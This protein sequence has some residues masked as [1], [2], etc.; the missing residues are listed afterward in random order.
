MIIKNLHFNGCSFVAG[1]SLQLERNKLGHDAVFPNE[2]KMKKN[3]HT[4]L[5]SKLNVPFINE[6][7]SGGSNKRAIRVSYE[8][9]KNNN[10]EGT[11]FIIGLSELYRDE[12]FSFHTNDYIEWRYE[13]FLK[14]NRNIEWSKQ[15]VPS[16]F[17]FHKFIEENKYED[18]IVDFAKTEFTF[19]KSRENEFNKLAQ[20]LTMLNSYI[21]S[22][23][24][25]L[26]V[27]SAMCDVLDVGKLNDINFMSFP[28][29][30][31]HWRDYIFSY[32][33]TYQYQHPC[34]DDQPIITNLLF[35]YIND[36][37]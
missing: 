15:L 35:N 34:I 16:S 21:E 2:E 14:F 13:T 36:N 25:R 12:K 20:N 3:F 5:S 30:I 17:A 28:N 24:G 23:G 10:I 1:T 19:F 8:Y 7:V 18:N 27:F 11:L 31:H 32:D 33:D 37:I 4:L 9:A 29:Q 22:K 26:L 6:A